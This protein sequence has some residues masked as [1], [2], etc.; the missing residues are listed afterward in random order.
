MGGCVSRQVYKCSRIN[1]CNLGICCRGRGP[2]CLKPKKCV[3]FKCQML[4]KFQYYG[5]MPITT[6]MTF[7]SS[8]LFCLVILLFFRLFCLFVWG[9]FGGEVGLF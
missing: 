5:V 2:E 8:L 3:E 9:F 1:V 7:S 6:I 4:E